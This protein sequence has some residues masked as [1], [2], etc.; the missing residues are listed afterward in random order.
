MS[1]KPGEKPRLLHFDVPTGPKPQWYLPRLC[2]EYD[3]HVMWIPSGDSQKDDSRAAQ[4][5]RWCQN[6]VMRDY[7][8]AASELAEFGNEWRPLGVLGLGEMAITSVHAAAAQ[9]GL[10]ANEPWSI[11]ALRN[12]YQQRKLLAKAGIPTPRFAE[13]HSARDLRAALQSVGV[14]AVLKPMAGVGSMATYRLDGTQDLEALWAEAVRNYADD[15]RGGSRPDFLVEELLVGVVLHTD[16]RYAPYVSVESLVQRGRIQHL[17]VTDKLGVTPDFRETGGIMP[18]TLQDDVIDSLLECASKSIEAMGIT[19]SATHIE[20]MLT[21]AG[22]RVIE[23][24]SRIGGGV[25][26]ML[27]HCCGYDSIMARAAIATGRPLPEFTQPS[28]ST[29]YYGIQAPAADVALMSQPTVEELLEIPE[30][31]EAELRYPVGARPRWKQGTPGGMVL[32]AVAVADT[33]GPLL[34]LYGEFAPGKRFT[35]SPS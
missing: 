26:E 7:E 10:P 23:V 9:L 31:V 27:H 34:D 30:V 32:R 4:F 1:F 16:P 33:A 13:V 6:S 29:A 5:D 35:Y 18:S 22:P 2:T 24:N 17:A 8:S 28:R 3:L 12:K 20:M 11:P 21:S 14:P 15:P 25:T 19:N